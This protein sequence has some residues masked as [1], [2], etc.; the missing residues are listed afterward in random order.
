MLDKVTIKDIAKK[1][2]V[3]VSTVSKVLNGYNDVSEK[4]K[5]IVLEAVEQMK[6]VPDMMARNLVKSENK[7]VAILIEVTDEGENLN[8]FNFDITIG[9][10]QYM[11]EANYE[12]VLLTTTPKKQ[13]SLS[14]SKLFYAN[15]LD[16]IFIMGLNFSDN[17]YTEVQTIDFPNVLLDFPARGPRGGSV[18]VNNM[19]GAMLATEHLLE[20]GHRKIA[21]VNGS[22]EAHVCK[23]RLNGYLLALNKYNIN[24]DRKIIYDSDFSEAGG[25]RAI[26]ELLKIDDSITAVF[27][28][29][30]FMASGVI[31]YL[32]SIGKSVPE[33]MSV[34][35]FDD[36]VIASHMTPRLTTIRQ[37]RYDVGVLAATLL[38]NL[39]NGQNINSVYVEPELMVRESTK[40]RSKL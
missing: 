33:D 15:H 3:S 37:D 27:A 24:M 17:Y 32:Q 28:V 36:I 5:A 20:L 25:G 21:L 1:A 18:G 23:E 4:T 9:F 7:R 2:N 29:S 11:S 30:D 19:K 38:L 26:K 31:K 12:V 39:I 34:V 16:G 10:R 6:Y 35:G 22:N 8:V 14:L 40:K 13:K